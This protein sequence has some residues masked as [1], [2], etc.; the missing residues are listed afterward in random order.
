MD[1]QSVKETAKRWEISER[2]VRQYC[3][4]GR[5]AG[6]VL[7]GKMWNIPCDAEKPSRKKR[8][9]AKRNTLLDVLRE[10]KKEKLSGGIYHRLQIDMT[11]NSNHMEGSCLSHDQTRYIYETR[12]IDPGDGAVRVDDIMETLNHFRCID[13]VIDHAEQRLSECYFKELHRI[14]KTNSSDA[15]K[16][17]FV[18][19]DYKKIPNEVGGRETAAP[20]Q[21]SGELKGLLKDYNDGKQKT[22]DDILDFHVRFERIHPFQDGN[23]RV[24][25]LI[26]LGECLKNNIVPF[27]I[28]DDLK[29]YYYRGLSEWDHERGYLRDT[30]LTA[31]S[32]FKKLMDYF[33][34]PYS[35]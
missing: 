17:W 1:Y 11:Y 28:T 18:V 35:E 30:C 22:L 7:S 10:E 31:Q 3:Q 33:R 27:I 8:S 26:L 19:G 12:T 15:E 5:I 6:A 16:S 29:M 24:G 13:T 4:S 23:G 2:A 21:V 32:Y 14:L 25:R 20:E 34:I 9:D